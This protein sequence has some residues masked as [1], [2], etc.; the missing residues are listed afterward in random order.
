LCI[1][2]SDG[3]AKW[4]EKTLFTEHLKS[5]IDNHQEELDKVL[6]KKFDYD[7]FTEEEWSLS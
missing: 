1:D 4:A 7:P 5:S 2:G 6:G 3:K